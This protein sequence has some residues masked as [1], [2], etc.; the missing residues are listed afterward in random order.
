[1]M[2][3]A[4]KTGKTVYMV[5]SHE[6]GAAVWPEDYTILGAFEDRGE[7][8]DLVRELDDHEMNDGETTFVV[9]PLHVLKR[10]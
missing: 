6:D 5:V 1:M 3:P 7:A 2:I 8:D 10:E 9:Y 4:K